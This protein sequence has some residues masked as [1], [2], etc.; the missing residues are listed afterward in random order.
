VLLIL[1]IAL[2][3]HADFSLS[4][5]SQAWSGTGNGAS[6]SGNETNVTGNDISHCLTVGHASSCGYSQ[7]WP[8]WCITYLS[9][10]VIS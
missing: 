3:N 2:A 1:I 4:P 8:I 6:W 10:A 9:F 7:L 5:I